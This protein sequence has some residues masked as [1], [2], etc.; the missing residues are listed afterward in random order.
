MRPW[1]TRYTLLHSVS[2]EFSYITDSCPAK[3]CSDTIFV[4]KGPYA[5]NTG[6][7]KPPAVRLGEI[8]YGTVLA[9]P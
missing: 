8:A 3:S 7:G 1:C 5:A 4:D 2:P 9:M 6:S